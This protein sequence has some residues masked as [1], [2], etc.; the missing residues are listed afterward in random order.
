[1]FVSRIRSLVMHSAVFCK[2]FSL[3]VLVFDMIY[4]QIVFPYSS[5]VLVKAVYAFRSVYLDLP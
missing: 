4:Y 2:V 3:L 5:A 1:M